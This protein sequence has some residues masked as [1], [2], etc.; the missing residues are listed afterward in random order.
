MAVEF[1]A[2]C[3][4]GIERGRGR[5]KKFGQKTSCPVLELTGQSDVDVAGLLKFRSKGEIC[6]RFQKWNPSTRLQLKRYLFSIVDVWV[7]IDN[8]RLVDEER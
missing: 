1:P 2:R 6:G 8:E 7:G 5:A 4:G 3:S